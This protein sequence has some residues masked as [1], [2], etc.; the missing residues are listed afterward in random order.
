MKL[1]LHMQQRLLKHYRL[2]L[3]YCYL[4]HDKK[5][6]KNIMQNTIFVYVLTFAKSGASLPQ[7]CYTLRS[8]TLYSW[9]FSTNTR[10]SQTKSI[11]GPVHIL[12][13][14]YHQELLRLLVQWVQISVHISSLYSQL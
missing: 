12:I 4:G 13:S 2:K 3:G 5:G 11:K 10:I 14:T 6:L 8:R 7:F 1:K 9:M